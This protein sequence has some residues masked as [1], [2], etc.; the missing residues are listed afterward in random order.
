MK[1]PFFRSLSL[2]LLVLL[3][4]SAQ[5]AGQTALVQLVEYIGA[6]Y[7]N[8]VEDG[9]IISAEEYAEMTEFAGLL[10]EGVA[11]LPEAEGKAALVM[12]SDALAKAIDARAGNTE[13]KQLAQSIRGTLVGTYG[14]PVRPA[15]A[16]DMA[17]ARTLYQQQC[18]VCHGADGHGDGPAGAMLEPAPT[19]FH[20]LTRFEGR[21][22][23]GLY[24][25]VTD[26]VEGT[27]MAAFGDA[28]SDEDR[29][30]LTFLVGSFAVD[31]ALA[32]RGSEALENLP[33][34]ART[35]DL[36][37]LL[38]SAPEDIRDQH[39][40]AAYAASAYLRGTPDALFASNR[41]L[42]HSAAQLREANRLYSDGNRDG[43]RSAALSA[44]LDGFEMIEQQLAAV[45]GALMREAE[46]AFMAVREAIERQRPAADVSAAVDT[47]LAQLQRAADALEGDGLSPM[48]TATASFVILFREGLE[49]L[50][51]VAALLAFTR[52]A[53]APRATHYIHLGWIAALA[54]GA[55]TWYVAATLISF[56][57]T[58]RELT[59][60]IAGL[61]AAGILFYM[62][63]WMHSH[64]NSQK[65]LGYIREQVDSAL[66]S[67][68]LWAL[69]LV[70]FVSVYREIFETI[71]FYQ[72]LWSQVGA[73]SQAW[74]F[75]GIG[76]AI[77]ALAVVCVLFFR[78]GMRLPLGLFFR[79]TGIVL[80]VLSF[81]LLG[82]GI[83][84]LQEAGWLGVRY[85]DLPTIDW[86]GIY[87]TVQG[88]S[89]QLV[90]ILLGLVFWWRSQRRSA[91]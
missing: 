59:E 62:G 44:Y 47:A 73:A 9:E 8:A 67:G 90:L 35:L 58:A 33:G 29:W 49:A 55:V 78:L 53:N 42:D 80:L 3:A 45:D 28:L 51:I 25:T 16:P 91:G 12:Q 76:A 26:G 66:G 27:G 41:F 56:S 22:L 48:A 30:A 68:T 19:D 5:A 13:V 43:A 1:N 71:L 64:A 74:V 72:A 65:W 17:H 57:G 63:F 82:R 6:D 24:T 15:S 2:C 54:A 83:A 38:G 77:A 75:Y 20:D 88:L 52:K 79:V 34:L 23:L 87:P 60:G 4:V 10:R 84:A 86:L 32:A 40:D 50:L 7:I 81:V 61:L 46:R 89:A 37:T 36:D 70:S 69:V 31:N 18:A 21:S 14:I 39:G 11:A 85:L